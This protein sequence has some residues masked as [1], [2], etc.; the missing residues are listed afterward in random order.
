MGLGA[1]ILDGREVVKEISR[2]VEAPGTS[3]VAEYMAL[4]EG[5]RAALKMGVASVEIRGDSQLVIRQMK[6]E[7]AVRDRRLKELHAEATTVAGSFERV[8]FIHV[9]REKN[10]RADELSK[11]AGRGED[12]GAGEE[13]GKGAEKLSANEDAAV[14]GCPQ[15]GARLHA[16]SQIFKDGTKHRRAECPVHGFVRFL[17]PRKGK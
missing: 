16:S 17:K 7:W 15:C 14:G 5:L 10:T 8:R 4:I 3:N 1:V 13:R 2:R 9:P 12:K 11:R 6:G